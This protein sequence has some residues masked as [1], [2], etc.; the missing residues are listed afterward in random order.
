MPHKID[1][2]APKFNFRSTPVAWR[3]VDLAIVKNIAKRCTSG[4]DFAGCNKFTLYESVAK[5]PSSTTSN[6]PKFIHLMDAAARIAPRLDREM[7]RKLNAELSQLA[8][9]FDADQPGPIADAS[10]PN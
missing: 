4:M 3:S 5:P 8:S 1:P 2:S 7:Y 6:A 10:A 9:E